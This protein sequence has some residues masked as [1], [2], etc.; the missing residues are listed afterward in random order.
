[1]ISCPNT[2]AIS[3]QKFGHVVRAWGAGV[4]G[5]SSPCLPA[6]FAQF[7]ELAELAELAEFAEFA[8]FTEFPQFAQFDQFAKLTEFAEFAEFA[9]WKVC[10][11]SRLVESATPEGVPRLP[12]AFKV[13]WISHPGNGTV[14]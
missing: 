8:E 12:L 14:R 1:M 13:G 3:V 10:G 5:A 4:T 6:E 7:A 2:G 9:K 11:T